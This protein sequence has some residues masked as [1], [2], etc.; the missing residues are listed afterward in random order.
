MSLVVVR[1]E[2]RQVRYGVDSGQAMGV[3]RGESRTIGPES[4]LLS[5]NSVKGERVAYH[6]GFNRLEVLGKIK[7]DPPP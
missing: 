7:T 2:R 6:W 3:E 1:R 5:V 4:H